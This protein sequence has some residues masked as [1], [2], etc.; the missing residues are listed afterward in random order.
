VQK[1]VPCSSAA[2]N[3]IGVMTKH[4]LITAPYKTDRKIKKK[5]RN[6]IEL[7][8]CPKVGKCDKESFFMIPPSMLIDRRGDCEDEAVTQET[9]FCHPFHCIMF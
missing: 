2:S 4:C 8:K 1:K 6:I 3:L 7:A 5:E 9:V